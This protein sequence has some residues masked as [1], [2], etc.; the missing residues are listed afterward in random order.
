MYLPEVSIS[1]KYKKS[2]KTELKRI[3]TSRDAY[4]VFQLMFNSD[5]IE[6]TEEMILICLNRANKVIGFYKVSKGGVSGTVCDPKV[7]FFTALNCGASNIMLA[8]NHPSGNLS[9][10]GNDLDLTRKIRDAARL[11]D[12]ELLDHLIVTTEGYYSFQ[13]EGTM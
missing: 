8:H 5:T 3:V 1:I 6:W 11:F 2:L 7:I 4:E 9:P 10:S 12:M 13:D